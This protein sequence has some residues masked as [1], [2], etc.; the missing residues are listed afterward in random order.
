MCKMRLSCGALVFEALVSGEVIAGWDVGV[1]TMK[2][3]ELARFLV[4]PDYAFGSFGCP[5]R[6][7]PNAT[8]KS[9]KNLKLTMLRA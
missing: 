7:P 4:G 1:A 6:I 8:S 2:K 3:G 9:K 5:P